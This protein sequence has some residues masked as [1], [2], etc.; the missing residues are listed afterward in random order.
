MGSHELEASSCL[1]GEDGNAAC[2]DAVDGCA[3]CLLLRGH[4]SGEA[5]EGAGGQNYPTDY[6]RHKGSFPFGDRRAV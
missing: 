4:A 6:T 5:N 3:R 1:D 2:A